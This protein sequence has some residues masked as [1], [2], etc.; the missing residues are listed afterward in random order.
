MI[1]THVIDT[2]ILTRI[3]LGCDTL[4]VSQ[5]NKQ[6]NELCR[7]YAKQ[8]KLIRIN[9]DISKKKMLEEFE[10]ACFD[11]CMGFTH[12]HQDDYDPEWRKCP[13]MYCDDFLH[14]GDL[15]YDENFR[16]Y[17]YYWFWYKE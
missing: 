16:G 15:D 11:C 3:F 12:S 4:I 1:T 17:R 2:D 10:N 5:V 8:D 14:V 6:C 13:E 7:Q 9:H